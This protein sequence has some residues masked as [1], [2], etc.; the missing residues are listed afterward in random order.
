MT[1]GRGF[2]VALGLSVIA[3]GMAPAWAGGWGAI[4][5][6]FRDDMS[7]TAYGIGRGAS[8]AEAGSAAMSFCTK[9]GGAKCGVVVSYTNCG[10]V[11]TGRNS[12][13]YGMADSKKTAEANALGGCAG[14]TCRIV[15]S[16][17]NN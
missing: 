11:A 13:G 15:A 4:A 8:M 17:C 16:D 6:D 9:A 14:S 10:A 3:T 1:L 12:L 2:L 7:N 5:V